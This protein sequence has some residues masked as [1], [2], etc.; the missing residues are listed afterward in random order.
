MPMKSHRAPARPPVEQDSTRARENPLD[1]RG[2]LSLGFAL[3]GGARMPDVKMVHAETD[4]GLR[5]WLR[6]QG[7]AGAIADPDGTVRE[8]GPRSL[9]EEV[10]AAH[11]EYVDLG[12]PEPEAFGLTVGPERAQVWLEGPGQVIAPITAGTPRGT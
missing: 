4:E 5:V 11:A 9:W 6:D 2:L 7:G 1:P 8:Y 3:Y 10:G 12:R